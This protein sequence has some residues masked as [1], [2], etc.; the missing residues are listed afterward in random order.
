VEMRVRMGA[1]SF[2]EMSVT[3]I[4]M[5]QPLIEGIT[6]KKTSKKKKRRKKKYKPR[7]TV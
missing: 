6:A 2:D 3:I 1:K 5:A 4:R 7:K